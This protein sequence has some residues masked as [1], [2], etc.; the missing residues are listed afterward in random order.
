[1][2]PV[3]A[4]EVVEIGQD[5]V[6][7]GPYRLEKGSY[8]IWVEDVFPGFDDGDVFR[9]EAVSGNGVHEDAWANG[10]YTT[11]TMD[12]VDCEHAM[13]FNHMPAGEWEFS[14][15]TYKN[16]T[17]MGPVHVSV[18]EENISWSTIA[19]IVGVVCITLGVTTIGIAV[20]GHRKGKVEMA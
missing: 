16:T 19:L 6:V 1:M 8:A 11:S 13:G 2:P 17:G 20:L 15:W 9:V 12:G 5:P 18:T 10:E 14:I 3:V 4:H 7:I